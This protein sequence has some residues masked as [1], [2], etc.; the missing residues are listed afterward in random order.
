MEQA[1]LELPIRLV[2]RTGPQ[3]GRLLFSAGLLGISVFWM[4]AAARIFDLDD[5]TFHWPHPE[6]F[7][8]VLIPLCGLPFVAFGAAGV[9]GAVLKMRP[10]SPH[11]HIQVHSGGLLVKSLFAL[12]RHDWTAL[13]KFETLR[14]ERRH[15]GGK[16]IAYFTAANET[17]PEGRQ[18]EILRIFPD[19]YGA[20]NGEDDAFALTAWFNELRD[21]SQQGRLEANAAV[22][23]PE[24]FRATA[25]SMRSTRN[26]L[27]GGSA[28][29]L[30]QSASPVERRSTVERR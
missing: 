9:I 10:G 20:G 2:P 22:A 21:L 13:P 25:I 27:N 17:S 6:D 12:R 24:P 18:R 1:T 5:G 30:Q 4:V 26:L 29:V 8:D 11:F 28:P 15:K 19:E 3:V 23:V 14:V 16:L 7:L